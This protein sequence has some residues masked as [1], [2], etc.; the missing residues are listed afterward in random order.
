MV[1]LALFLIIAYQISLIAPSPRRPG[2]SFD[3]SNLDP[4]PI[5]ISASDHQFLYPDPDASEVFLAKGQSIIISCPG[6]QLTLNSTS[7]GTTISATCKQGNK[8]IANGTTFKLNKITCSTNPYHRA[9]S[10][11]QSCES[12]GQEIEIGFIVGNDSFVREIA[13]CFDSKYRN[14]FY[15][16]FNLTRSIAH[17][18]SD[19][20]RPTF[21]EELVYTQLPVRMTDLYLLSNQRSVINCL[22]GLPANSTRYIK[23]STDYFLVRGHLTAK[24][25]FVYTYQQIATFHYVNTAPQWQSFNSLNWDAVESDVRN[26]AAS[27]KLD[28]KVYTGIYGVTTLPHAETGEDV[29]LFLFSRYLNAIA[30]PELFWK[31]VYD[32]VSKK[33]IALLGINNPYQKDV[34]KSIICE[35]ISSFITWLHWKPA[36]V[37]AGYSYACTVDEF[38]R[39]V[40]YLPE[41]E[42]S[43]LLL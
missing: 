28:L 17:R 21:V 16:T 41:F 9:S 32:P 6:G 14:P 15:S 23:D 40:S 20:I 22:L 38:R 34:V 7:I 36:D 19:V 39:K 2:C 27:N 43:G 18:E 1:Q 42:V 8:F 25:D 12:G 35:D 5:I 37:Q 10:L 31:V 30:V 13:I 26:Y 33:G 4:E 29:P 24:D 11:K 3:L